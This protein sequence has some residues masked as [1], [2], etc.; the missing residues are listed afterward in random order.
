[1]EDTKENVLTPK[2]DLKDRNGTQAAIRAGYSPRTAQEQAI[3]PIYEE[4]LPELN[5]RQKSFCY[6]Y[7]KDRNATQ[8]YIRAGYATKGARQCA[9]DLLSNPYIRSKI[10]VLIKAQIESLALDQKLI[11][12]ELLKSA[13]VDIADAYNADTNTLKEIC[14]MPEPLR[15]A[16]VAVET[17]ELFD[18]QGKDRQLI[19]YTK[20]IKFSDRL[21]AL[22]LLGKHLKLFTEVHEV[23]GLE[24]LAERMKAARK[25]VID[26]ERKEQGQKY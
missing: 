1:M 22:E 4:D 10:N 26:A 3:E 21:Q 11:I 14:D 23:T 18:G 24:N 9:S 7:I 20:R 5:E 15:K 13:T 6:E 2:Q 12:K 17:E 19:G 8:A 25:R 16:I